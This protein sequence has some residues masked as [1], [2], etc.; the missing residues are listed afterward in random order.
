M[1]RTVNS[2]YSLTSIKWLIFV[3]VRCSVSL[4][5]RTALL[6]VIYTNLGFKKDERTLMGTF[7]AVILALT[8]PF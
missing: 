8:F 6:N 3:V 2:D 7:I 1:V 5:V 4:E